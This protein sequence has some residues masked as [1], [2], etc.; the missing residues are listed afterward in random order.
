MKDIAVSA[1][2][3]H[4]AAKVG[5]LFGRSRFFI[6]VDPTTLEWEALDN[7][8]NL[9]S[10]Q[11]VGLMTAKSLHQKKIRTVITGKCGPKA[12]GELQAA[13][14]EVFLNAKGTVRQ[15]LTGYITG[16]LSPATKSNVAVSH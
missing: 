9:S 4:L 2:G 12:F 14:I 13:G 6:L 10:T 7:L 16:E 15:A 3:K 11:G 5:P 8:K 1:N